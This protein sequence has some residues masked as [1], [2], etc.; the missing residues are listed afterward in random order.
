MGEGTLSVV[1]MLVAIPCYN[2][3]I[4]IRRVL[5]EFDQATLTQIR[6]I[7][8]IDNQSHD[9]T[10]EAAQQALK[11]LARKAPWVR[12]SVSQNASNYGLGGTH[13][14]AFEYALKNGFDWVSVLHGDNQAKSSELY[15]L[16]NVIHDKPSVDAILGS[17]F[18]RGSQRPGYSWVRIFGN[19]SLNVIYTLMSGRWTSDLGSGLNVYRTS[20]LHLWGYMDLTEGFTFNME[21]LLKMYDA[22]A[23]VV[24]HPITWR[25]E[26][27][28]S[29]AR[30]WRV[31]WGSL[32]TAL[33]WRL[34]LPAKPVSRSY[35][36]R[37]LWSHA[38]S[39]GDDK[40][41]YGQ[42]YSPVSTEGEKPVDCKVP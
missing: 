19:L 3:E 27:Q 2:C 25:E 34:G 23:Q 31:G 5:A 6:E 11:E 39:T 33:K 41:S 8:V 17:R 35:V 24:F 29:S 28:V 1:K 30:N 40:N 21:L 14:V 10:I 26:D 32:M 13:K 16:I 22:K 7:L 12:L 9:G 4:Q 42:G 15:E 37:C 18:A 38:E 20:A 36:S